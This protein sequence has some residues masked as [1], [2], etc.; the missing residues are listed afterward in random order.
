MNGRKTVFLDRDGTINVEKNYLYKV[1]EFEFIHGAIEAI[2]LFN[3]NGFYV[4]VISNQAGIARGFYTPNDVHILHDFIQRELRKHN[5]FID[6][7]FYCPHHP[8]GTVEGYRQ[9]CDCRKPNTGMIAQSEAKFNIDRHQS[10]VVGDL[11]S[12]I[13]LAENAG[14]K[15]VL[16][17]TGYGLQTLEQVEEKNLK[18]TFVAENILE[19]AKKIVDYAR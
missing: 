7:F 17:K 2:K 13:R 5:A 9:N 3:D 1:E 18:I 10:F 14:M 4:I 8:D 6:A 11:W 15:A 19:A 16:V 12:D